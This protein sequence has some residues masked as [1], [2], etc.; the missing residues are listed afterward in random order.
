MKTLNVYGHVQISSQVNA[1][2]GRRL[3][4]KWPT[5]AAS[6]ANIAAISGNSGNYYLALGC[7]LK[8]SNSYLWITNAPMDPDSA[9]ALLNSVLDFQVSNW[10]GNWEGEGF[11]AI[12]R[13]QLQTKIN[14]ADYPTW[15]ASH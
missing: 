12:L 6:F 8:D 7:E 5:H 3:Y 2:G 4:D 14:I 9:F 11:N 15:F 13:G 10:P 1:A